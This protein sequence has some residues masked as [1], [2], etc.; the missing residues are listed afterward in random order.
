MISGSRQIRNQVFRSLLP[1][2]GASSRLSAMQSF[3]SARPL[4]SYDY[5]EAPAPRSRMMRKKVASIPSNLTV[6]VEPEHETP[7]IV[8]SAS[9]A[10][11]CNDPFESRSPMTLKF[12][13]RECPIV[14]KLHLVT[15]ADDVPRGVWPVFRLMDENG[16]FRDPA[17]DSMEN[18]IATTGSSTTTRRTSVDY[19]IDELKRQ[20][21]D[22]YP[23]Q[24][25]EITKSGLLESAKNDFADTQTKNTLLRV[26]AQ[27]MRLR[28]MD[29]I[30]LNA[31]R[32]G[33]ISFYMTCRGEEAIHMGAASALDLGDPVFA[34]YR[35]QGLLM[36]RGFTL[37]QF[38]N[39]CFSNKAD[40]GKGRQMPVHYGSRALNY[41]TISSPLGTQIPQA[42]GAAYRLKLAGLP[43]VVLCVFGDGCASTTDFHSGMNFAATLNAP[44]IF[45]CR[46]NG[47]AISTPVTD[48]YA[49]DG[50]V[51]R[52]PGYG[53]AA[54]RVDG[55]DVFA[56]HAAVR[57]AKK[58][59]LENNAPVFIEAM[60]Y[61]Q[62]HHSTSDD[63]TRYRSKEEIEDYAQPTDPLARLGY[64]LRRHNWMT[65]EKEAEIR[66]QEKIAVLKAMGQAERLPPPSLESLFTD[67]YHEIPPHLMEQQDQLRNH[68]AKYPQKYK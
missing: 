60:T 15:P 28:E 3:S 17:C 35:E 58:Y 41:H 68:M 5:H 2:R 47:Y 66:S 46:N 20:L 61:R 62:G 55:N 40:L 7:A 37:D 29:E 19:N 4:P 25:T 59:A 12:I 43:N 16:S 56:M 57:E 13:D 64:F 23:F 44:V 63:S 31:Q 1:N 11:V 24:S 67:V 27:M 6:I 30:L 18:P 9:E 21:L 14:S 33:R 38:C 42:V 26:H 39:Q 34:Q 48:Q 8:V 54:I 49:G 52:A 32:Q 36:W 10:D 45:L 22:E 51:S 50:I 65:T 53:M